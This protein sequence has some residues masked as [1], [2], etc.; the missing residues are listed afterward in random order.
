MNKNVL[1]LALCQGLITTGNIMLVTVTALIGLQLS[2]NESWITLPVATQ[3]LGL[4]I[5]TIP[6][7]LLMAKIGRKNG[8]SLGNAI[9]IVG[10]LIAVYALEQG[11]FSLFCIATGLIGVAIGFATLYRF[12][13]IEA[14]PKNPIRAISFIMASGVIAALLGPNLAIWVGNYFPSLNFSNTFV[15]LACLYTLAIFILQFV[16][17][18]KT[19]QIK[20]KGPTRDLKA[21]LIQPKFIIAVTVAMI[22]FTLMNLLM[23]ATPLAMHRHGFSFEESAFVIQ[24]H[25]LGMFIP[26]FFTGR[27]IEKWGAIKVMIIGTLLITL[28]IIINLQ[29]ISHWHFLLALFLLGVGWNLMFISATQM[30]TTTYRSSEKAKTQAA[31]EFLVFSMVTLSSLSAGWLESSLGWQ[32]LNLF[33]IAPLSIIMM[34]LIY[35]DKHKKSIIIS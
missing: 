5:A 33:S 11:I 28:C 35:Y 25:V 27:L 26:S 24:W 20:E 9:G 4:L 13:V 32:I 14:D 31:N 15:A 34:G 19:Q 12:A 2:P 3:S 16:T 10:I 18:T 29:G 22:S 23:T 30:V 8:F 21:I 6:A 17:F 1:I 7:S